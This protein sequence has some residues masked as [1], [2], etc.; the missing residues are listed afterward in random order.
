M[1]EIRTDSAEDFIYTFNQVLL[2]GDLDAAMRLYEPDAV[3]IPE[4][5]ATPL[6]GNDIRAALSAVPELGLP[7][8][9]HRRY[10][11]T[12]G[13]IALF[14]GDWVIDGIGP[15]GRHVH[16]EGTAIDVIRRGTDGQ[17]RFL[18]HNPFG[19]AGPS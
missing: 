1:T 8:T 18:V 16:R 13:D 3:Y 2:G 6:R 17:Y 11:Y 9:H 15:D 7:I 4:P 5:P 19:L 10:I 14:N 12:A